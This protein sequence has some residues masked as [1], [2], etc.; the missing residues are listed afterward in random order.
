MDI[1]L[2]YYEKGYPCNVIKE[3]VPLPLTALIA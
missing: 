1:E 3:N 2:D